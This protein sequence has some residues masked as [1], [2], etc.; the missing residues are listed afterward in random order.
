MFLSYSKKFIKQY[1]KQSSQIKDKFIERQGL[2]VTNLFHPLLNN[3]RLSGEYA[4]CRSIN[5]TGDIRAVFEELSENHVEFVA[6]G[7][8]SELY[9]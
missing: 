2:F 3:H 1:S 5:I 7:S 4:G 8:H 9:S 6:I